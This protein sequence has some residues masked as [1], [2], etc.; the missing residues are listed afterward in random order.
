MWQASLHYWA[1]GSLS[2]RCWQE[3]TDE[4]RIYLRPFCVS[5]AMRFSEKSHHAPVA[6]WGG[7]KIATIFRRFSAYSFLSLE[8]ASERGR[9]AC[10]G[11]ETVQAEN[12][13]AAFQRRAPTP[14]ERE[15]I[16]YVQKYI[17]L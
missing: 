7:Q 4:T 12:E 15:T 3:D 11:T 1:H 10:F 13:S 5:A 16:L 8:S 17:Y 9:A 2:A 6:R 14:R